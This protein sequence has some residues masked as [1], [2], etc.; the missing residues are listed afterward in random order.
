MLLECLEEVAFTGM[1]SLLSEVEIQEWFLRMVE[2]AKD[3][4]LS[5][6]DF[7]PVL[8]M[9]AETTGP[10]ASSGLPGVMVAVPLNKFMESG[11][12][13]NMLAHWARHMSKT[14]K[15]YAIA[16]LTDT[17][18]LTYA[19]NEEFERAREEAKAKFGNDDFK[20]IPGAIE[21]LMCVLETKK[22]SRTIILDYDRNE[23]GQPRITRTLDSL[24]DPV[25][26]KGRLMGWLEDKDN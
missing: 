11:Q 25:N 2:Q 1:P 9:L 15:G 3:V 4:L 22:G 18:R 24:E 23:K 20:N 6:D 14:A 16:R 5:G 7:M 26:L 13:K 17:Y 8:L 12:K 19:S 21:N 10:L